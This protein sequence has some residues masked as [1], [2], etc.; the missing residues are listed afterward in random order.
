MSPSPA[1]TGRGPTGGASV[2]SEAEPAAEDPCGCGL[3]S[4]PPDPT[5]TSE[6]GRLR[7]S[8]AEM[9]EIA[10]PPIIGLL[11]CLFLPIANESGPLQ[12]A[13]FGRVVLASHEHRVSDPF[14]LPGVEK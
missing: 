3:P 14:D 2:G 6:W 5:Q 9:M 11:L 13:G 8:G 7:G 1:T 4:S 10:A 12:G